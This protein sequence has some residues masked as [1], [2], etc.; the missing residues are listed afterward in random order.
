MNVHV[1]PRGGTASANYK[2]FSYTLK[3]ASAA[4]FGCPKKVKVVEDVLS[5]TIEVLD[6][7]GWQHKHTGTNMIK[8]GLTP[9]VKR[10]LKFDC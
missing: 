8:R 10:D 3:C 7:T 9:Q 2:R 4:C 6:A 5:N 1:G